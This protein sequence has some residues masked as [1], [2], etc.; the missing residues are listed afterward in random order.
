M[1]KC[2]LQASRLAVL[3][4]KVAWLCFVTFL[5]WVFDH[6]GV[7]FLSFYLHSHVDIPRTRTVEA[8]VDT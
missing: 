6:F 1:W 3:L 4:Y 8:V 7:S 5:S 2:P